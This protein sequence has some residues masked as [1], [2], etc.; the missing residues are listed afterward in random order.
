MIK[1]SRPK[2]RNQEWI[3]KSVKFTSIK[4][5]PCHDC[6]LE[7]EVDLLSYNWIVGVLGGVSKK[8][9]EGPLEPEGGLIADGHVTGLLL[10]VVDTVR[11][12]G[13]VV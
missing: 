7:V 10:S 4:N 12:I 9:D 13:H 6:H 5:Q 11:G 3:S 8:E 2:A 1:G